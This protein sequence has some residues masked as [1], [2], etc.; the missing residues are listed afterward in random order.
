MLY[1]FSI[2]FRG[3]L[4]FSFSGVL[5]ITGEEKVKVKLRDHGKVSVP[6]KHLLLRYAKKIKANEKGK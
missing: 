6:K 1:I 5:K 2:S 4:N 3:R